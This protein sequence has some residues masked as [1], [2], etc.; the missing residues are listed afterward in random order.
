VLPGEQIEVQELSGPR[1]NTEWRIIVLEVA[2][3]DATV[4]TQLETMLAAEGTQT[5]II[6]GK[7]HLKRDKNKLV[8]EV[9]VQWDEQQNFFDSGPQDRHFVLD[10]ASGRLFFGNGSAG[11]IPPAAAAIQAAMFR[12]GGGIAGNVAVNTI[13]Q[14]LSA[15]SGVQGVSNP[16]AAEGGADGETLEEFALRAPK[17]LRNRGSAITLPD[18]ENLARE[19]SAGVAVARAIPTLDP[20]GITLPG[21][22]TLI[23]IPHSQEPRPVPSFG[24]REEVQ[25]FLEQHAPGDLAAAH[26]IRVI[27]PAYL[28]IDIKATLA[29]KDPTE[30]GTVEQAARM[31]LETFLHPLYGGP[32][33]KG[34]DLGRNVYLSDIAAVLGDVAGVDFVAELEISVNGVLQ[35]GVAEVPH[36]Q[37]VVAGELQLNLTLA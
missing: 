14:L 12:S 27:G 2:D 15:V 17:G 23:I 6:L 13:T 9:W 26:G 29:P 35:D 25:S 10:H 33:G 30:A 32:G 5:D 22:I 20:N 11:K 16:R 1:V 36:G 7:I 4:V 21:W 34:W 28:P 3:D 19:A 37:I 8:T 24:L 18:Y 31:A